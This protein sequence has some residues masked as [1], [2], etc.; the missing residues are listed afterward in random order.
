VRI[1]DPVVP[2]GEG[3]PAVISLRDTVRRAVLVASGE[4]DATT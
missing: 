4:H 3:W 1:A 2:T